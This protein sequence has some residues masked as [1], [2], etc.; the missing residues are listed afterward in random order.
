MAATW[1]PIFTTVTGASTTTIDITN[2]PQTYTDLVLSMVTR[3]AASNNNDIVV[4]F[5]NIQTATYNTG[6]IQLTGSTISYP[7]L[8]NT[9]GPVVNISGT[10]ANGWASV[11][12]DIQDYTN[13]NLNRTALFLS[14]SPGDAASTQ[15]MRQGVV[16][17]TTTNALTSLQF[18]TTNYEAG[19]SITMWGIKEA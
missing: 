9:N 10:R 2:I 1:I 18:V 8:T 11:Y 5:N 19:T 4:R 15:Q 6:R 17:N 7:F 16:M 13:T 12:L 14:G 3:D